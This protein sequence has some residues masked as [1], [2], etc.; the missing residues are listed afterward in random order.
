[1]QVEPAL[2]A[3]IKFIKPSHKKSSVLS[4]PAI[5][6]PLGD[7]TQITQRL[8]SDADDL[9]K[10]LH[11]VVP[12]AC[13]FTSVPIP[14]QEVLAS[15][16]NIPSE[17]TVTRTLSEATITSTP[18]EATVT[19]TPSEVTI[20][21]TPSEATVT[22]RPSEATVTNTPSEA[23]VT[24]TP[25]KETII[26]TPSEVTV[27]STPSKVPSKATVASTPSEVPS[28]ATVTSAPSKATITSTPSEATVTSTPFEVP[29]KATIT[30]TPSK[31]TVASTPSEVPSEATVT[32]TP[33]EMTV[34]SMPSEVAEYSETSANS[35][36]IPAPLT[37]LHKD[38]YYNMANDELEKE[39]EKLFCDLSISEQEA[40][41][42]VDATIMQQASAQWREQRNGRL[43]GS[44]FHDIYVR[45]RS[46]GPESLIKRVMG[47]EQSDLNHVPAIKWGV[48]NECVAR[49][50]YTNVMSTKHDNFACKL[51][52]LWVSPLYPANDAPT[53]ARSSMMSKPLSARTKS[54]YFRCL[55]KPL[56]TVIC[57]S[58]TRP[59]QHLEMKETAPVEVVATRNLM[60]L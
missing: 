13:I 47:Y 34:T 14:E 50:L 19:S 41:A 11:A 52:G 18:S 31:A 45:K 53:I 26:S 10:V 38:L 5:R 16:T 3:D 56:L 8:A 30:S 37:A 28:E 7:N 1:M 54:P 40:E 58:D 25:S 57:R 17:E 20:T 44:I 43:I 46:T 35:V 48:E 33:S 51:T 23:T 22:S 55:S 6:Q 49:Q 32:S 15:V 60:V 27:T 39:A 42:L 59:L 36:T 24:S 12:S 9:Y 2:V 4:V 21:S 29:S